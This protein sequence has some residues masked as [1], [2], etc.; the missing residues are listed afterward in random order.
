MRLPWGWSYVSD[1]MQKDL[2]NSIGNLCLLSPTLN[3][4]ASNKDFDNKKQV[5]KQAGLLVFR[6]IISNNGVERNTWDE[7]AINSRKER[8]IQFAIGQWKD[9]SESSLEATV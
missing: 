7:D 8:L 3:S 2:L 9:L 1:A 4:K 5:Y 6:D